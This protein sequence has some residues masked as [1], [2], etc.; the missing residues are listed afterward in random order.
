MLGLGGAV[1]AGGGGR[2]EGAS[3]SSSPPIEL[4]EEEEEEASGVGML[5]PAAGNAGVRL[6][7]SPSPSPHRN[8]W[9]K[10]N[11]NSILLLEGSFLVFLFSLF[12]LQGQKL[13]V[14]LHPHLWKI[15]FLISTYCTN[16]L[17]CLPILVHCFP[18]FGES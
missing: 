13:P 9:R 2:E 3:A 12:F 10:E 1:A 5:W 18:F 16:Y 8:C 17:L 14:K 11:S 15:L 6:L 4:E 7:S